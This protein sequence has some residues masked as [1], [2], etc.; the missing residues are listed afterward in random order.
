MV[1]R[2]VTKRIYLYAP[3]S[4]VPVHSTSAIRTAHFSAEPE[5]HVSSLGL[6]ALGLEPEGERGVGKIHAG[7]SPAYAFQALR[8]VYTHAKI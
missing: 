8:M 7:Q 2:W 4:D 3:G 5:V 1:Q 6:S